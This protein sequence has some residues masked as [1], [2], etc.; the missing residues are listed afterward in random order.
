MLATLGCRLEEEKRK[1]KEKDRPTKATSRISRANLTVG[2]HAAWR[3]VGIGPPVAGWGWGPQWWLCAASEWKGGQGP[4]GL[5]ELPG[6]GVGGTGALRWD[7]RAPPASAAS[8]HQLQ[9]AQPRPFLGGP[10]A[11]AA[12]AGLHV[13]TAG[14][15]GVPPPHRR[16]TPPVLLLLP[17]H[18]LP[19]P[20][21]LLALQNIRVVQPNLV[22]AVGLPMEICREDVLSQLEFFGQFGEWRAGAAGLPGASWPD[23]AGGWV[24]EEGVVGLGGWRSAAWC[25]GVKLGCSSW[26]H[27]PARAIGFG[28]Q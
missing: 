26:F 20:L 17:P 9:P 7:T 8:T 24:G 18:T 15:A 14:M 22:Y 3:R 4:D 13:C 10:A 16:P 21:L 25:G 27:E 1:L 19:P 2:A 6:V 12:A 23:W 5:P 11:A 28:E